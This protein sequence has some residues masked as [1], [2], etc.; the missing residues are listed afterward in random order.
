MKDFRAVAILCLCL[1]IGGAIGERVA[2][3]APSEAEDFVEGLR[4]RGLYQLAERFCRDALADPQL[5][6]RD[7]T[8]LTVQLIRTMAE[9]F[10]GIG[11]EQERTRL[12]NQMTSL[13]DEFCEKYANTDWQYLV[14]F[15][16]LKG[17][18]TAGR[19]LRQETE[20]ALLV[21][22]ETAREQLMA[23]PRNTLRNAVSGL[24]TLEQ[25]V[26]STLRQGPGRAGH[27]SGESFSEEEW[28]S[29][30]K[31]VQ[32]QLSLAQQELARTYLES[33][34]DFAAGMAEAEKRLQVLAQ[35]PLAHPLGFPARIALAEGQRVL[36]ARAAARQV[37]QSIPEAELSLA[38]KFVLRAELIRLAL[39]EQREEQIDAVIS[40]GRQIDGQTSPLLDV[41]ILEGL[42]E[43]WRRLQDRPAAERAAC[44]S[45]IRELIESLR[46]SGDAYWTLRGELL[47]ARSI[48]R[49]GSESDGGMQTYAAEMAYRRGQLDEAVAGFL[50][51]E[52]AATQCGDQTKAFQLGMAAAAIEH[53]R[54]RD[55]EAF[56][57]YN[58]LSQT[59][60]EQ[61]QAARA[62]ELAVFHAGQLFKTDPGQYGLTYRQVLTDYLK[63]WPES[64]FACRAALY[65]AKLNALE[66]RWKEAGEWFLQALELW[67]GPGLSTTTSDAAGNEGQSPSIAVIDEALAGLSQAVDPALGTIDPKQRQE[68]AREWAGRLMQW[69]SHQGSQEGQGGDAESL[70]LQL[71]AVALAAEL[72]LDHVHDPPAAD[73]VLQ[74]YMARLFA[75]AAN[76]PA[77]TLATSGDEHFLKL[78]HL[79]LLIS[80]ELRRDHAQPACELLRKAPLAARVAFARAIEP[81]LTAEPPQVTQRLAEWTLSVLGDLLQRWGEIKPEDRPE[82][83]LLYGKLLVIRGQVE[84]AERWL[85]SLARQFP[86]RGDIQENY[87]LLLAAKPNSASRGAALDLFR[88]IAQ[89]TP[90]GS[91]R[92][93]RAKYMTAWLHAELGDP[94]R[95][96][97]VIQLLKTLHPGLGSPELQE[98]FLRLEE[99]C[100]QRLAGGAASSQ[101]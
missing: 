12:L 28:L 2:A 29:L 35:L 69:A 1:G 17:Q 52:T 84:A 64:E 26:G 23:G 50:R 24:K 91:P 98:K 47:V 9:H 100:Q 15:E 51:A 89:K 83:G 55:A 14:Q 101:F 4:S 40:Q 6:V 32:F 10:L 48:A 38:Q 56:Q 33:S 61:S 19:A 97:E 78:L 76:S 66:N 36:G 86:E 62:G 20:L 7:R 49:F 77:E 92:W 94:Q 95:S 87:A 5:T 39:A 16:V 3:A 25:L 53:S 8:M 44:E 21:A 43:K 79:Y 70:S 60:R 85:E 18:V 63:S 30:E 96:L 13:A 31:H 67:N 72:L 90:E 99:T 58:R 45:Q 34:P 57:L 73:A 41:A 71:A 54:N 93:F 81:R 65:L 42:V 75:I 27:Q 11:D 88:E 22:G 37:L 80:A 82:V 59:N 46:Q 68:K 74:P